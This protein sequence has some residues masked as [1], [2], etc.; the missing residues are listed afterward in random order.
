MKLSE[1]TDKWLN[2]IGGLKKPSTQASMKTHIRRFNGFFHN[3]DISEITEDKAQEYISV[4][5]KDLS[6][7]AVRGY[8]QTVSLI[9]ER[10]RK[11]GLIENVPEPVL[12]KGGTKPQLY[13]STEELQKLSRL[14][15]MY[16]LL[17]ETGLRAGE[18]L[19][20]KPGDIN[21]EQKTLT[22]NRSVYA[23]KTQDP[24][25][26][27]A[28]RTISLSSRLCDSI[29]K[30]TGG[31]QTQFLF[32]T[33]KGTPLYQT[34][35]LRKLHEV[36]KELKIN[37]TG[38]HAFRRGNATILSELGAP[39]KT[40]SYRQGRQSGNLT[41]DSYIQY[42]PSSDREIAEKLGEILSR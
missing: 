14:E 39:V 5:F 8:W 17:S 7:R 3:L 11:E 31:D 21:F 2:S 15:T 33:K 16:F 38:F 35:V 27:N 13:F 1:Y 29:R 10:A 22:V 20:L 28:F 37:R 34:N 9:L 24:K 30:E 18:M 25:T 42:K 26:A 4:L 41:V 12:P 23:A 40:I 6:P 36:L 19:G 32:Q